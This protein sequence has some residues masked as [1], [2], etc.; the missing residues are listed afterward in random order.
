MRLSQRFIRALPALLPLQTFSF[1]IN[2]PIADNDISISCDEPGYAIYHNCKLS[3]HF[4]SEK[5]TVGAQRTL[6]AHYPYPLL[7]LP[8]TVLRLV[9]QNLIINAAEAMTAPGPRRGRRTS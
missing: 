7:R 2:M 6:S 4:I 3:R 8:R 5:F 1:A 9:L